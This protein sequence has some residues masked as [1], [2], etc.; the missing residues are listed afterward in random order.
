[1]AIKTTTHKPK[2]DDRKVESAEDAL[3]GIKDLLVA[4]GYVSG[5]GKVTELGQRHPEIVKCY[6][7]AK[8]GIELLNH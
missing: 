4:Y 5:N 7:V 1:M 3:H 2:I 8:Q 6:N